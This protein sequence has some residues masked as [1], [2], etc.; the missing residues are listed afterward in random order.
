MKVKVELIIFRTTEMDAS[1][2]DPRESVNLPQSGAITT[3]PNGQA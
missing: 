1:L 2:Q 3:C